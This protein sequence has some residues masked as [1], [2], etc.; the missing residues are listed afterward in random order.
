MRP[1]LEII[2]PSS[3]RSSFLLSL[4]LFSSV[5][6]LITP[7]L[8][9]QIL[10]GVTRDSLLYLTRAHISGELLVEGLPT[11]KF[12]VEEREFTLDDLKLWSSEGKLKEAF[13]A[14][15]AAIVCPVE[16]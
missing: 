3:P 12:E 6:H 7:P 13:G 5:T 1:S 10:P 11:D 15:T 14:G 4:S 8:N 2:A 9:G 16:R